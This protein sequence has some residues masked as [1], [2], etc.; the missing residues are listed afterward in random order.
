MFSVGANLVDNL[1]DGAED[2]RKWFLAHP[3]ERFRVRPAFDGEAREVIARDDYLSMITGDFPSVGQDDP[4]LFDS[5]ITVQ[6]EP[7][8]RC[9]LPVRL[10]RNPEA[11][12]AFVAGVVERMADSM[13]QGMAI[14]ET[15][16][17]E[18]RALANNAAALLPI[19]KALMGGK[20]T[21]QALETGEAFRASAGKPRH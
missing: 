9:R 11:V 8:K 21:R 13:R 5:I 4:G 14:Q 18:H 19:D 15:L 12:P 16:P 17:P 1:S 20:I 3:G 7:G 6:I 2:D 10:P